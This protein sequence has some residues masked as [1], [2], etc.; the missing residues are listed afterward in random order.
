MVVTFDFGVVCRN[1]IN[2]VVVTI[3]PISSGSVLS[4]P[5]PISL[6]LNDGSQLDTN[7]AFS[8]R[9]NPVVTDIEP[10]NHLVMYVPI[11]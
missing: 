3:P 4:E 1:A 6:Q 10:R 5:L 11:L 9:L 8:Y 2:S 7:H